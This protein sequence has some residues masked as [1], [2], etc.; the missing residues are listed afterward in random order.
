MSRQPWISFLSRRHAIYGNRHSLRSRAS[1]DVGN[2]VS[3]RSA[4][5]ATCR[6]RPRDK[7]VA[8]AMTTSV[9]CRPRPADT[10]FPEVSVQCPRTG[11]GNSTGAVW[12]YSAATPAWACC[13]PLDNRGP[14]AG[15]AGQCDPPPRFPQRA[16]MIHS[17]SSM[18]ERI[19]ISFSRHRISSRR[20]SRIL[21]CTY[22]WVV[23]NITDPNLY[24][25][26]L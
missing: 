14:R 17:L 5:M 1:P 4:T 12:A 8:R 9:F 3:T 21:G 20:S 26:F 18:V 25:N 11:E 6:T 23:T 24:Q 22:L 15:V 2:A 7:R 13:F 10:Q 19:R 16:Q